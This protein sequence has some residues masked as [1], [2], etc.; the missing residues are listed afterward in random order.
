MPPT[1][2]LR[3]WHAEFSFSIK[4][5]G[6]LRGCCT[7]LREKVTT[8]LKNKYYK[9]SC[10]FMGVILRVSYCMYDTWPHAKEGPDIHKTLDTLLL[11]IDVSL[12]NDFN[13]PASDY[14]SVGTYREQFQHQHTGPWV[15]VP[16]ISRRLLAIEN[17]IREDFGCLPA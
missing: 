8:R 5:S 2:C 4:S 14:N 12:R 15:T 17:Q 16:R 9:V 13:Q 7:C 10:R 3:T 1:D 11:S 6:F